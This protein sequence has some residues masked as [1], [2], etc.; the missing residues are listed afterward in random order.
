MI[1]LKSGSPWETVTLT[2][3]S[4]DRALFAAL[5]QE[6]KE[7]ALSAEVGKMVVYVSMGPEWRPFGNP[8]RRR[9]IESVVLDKDV[10]ESIFNDVL[11]FLNNGKW[12]FDR[13][14]PYRRGY[15]LFGPPGSGKTSY[16]QALAGELGYN[17]CTMNLSERGMTDDR[18]SWLLSH[19]PARSLILLEDIDAAFVDRRITSQEAKQGITSLVTL[20]GLLN[21]LDGVTSTEERIIFMTTNYIE[22]LDPALI[23]PGRVDFKKY[24]GNASE[25]QIRTMFMRFF[26]GQGG[27]TQENNDS[28]SRRSIEVKEK[29]DT[30]VERLKGHAVSPA[31]LQGHFVFYREEP[32]DA[33]KNADEL[34]Q[35]N[36]GETL[37]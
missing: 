31:Q 22:R 3:L 8:R 33:I 25:H 19:V 14:I 29:A 12:Y 16:I 35:K 30:F 7:F 34:W 24:I 1:D 9:P 21:A 23:R 10:G 2:T 26:G 36:E 28:D 4:R 13:G 37:K 27:V 15:L 20:S 32:D 11:S 18:L 17:I 5:L 6:A